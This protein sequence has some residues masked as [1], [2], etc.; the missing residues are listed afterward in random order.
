MPGLPPCWDTPAA[1]LWDDQAADCPCM[2]APP[3]P[4]PPRRATVTIRTIGDML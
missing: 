4:E 2:P 3:E 1:C